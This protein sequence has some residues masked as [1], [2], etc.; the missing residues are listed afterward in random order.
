MAQINEH[1]ELLIIDNGSDDDTP[2]LGMQRAKENVQIKYCREDNLG[3]S[4]ARN[5]ALHDARGKYV[6]FLDDDATVA[7]GWLDEYV[8]FLGSPPSGKIVCVGGPVFPEFEKDRPNWLAANYGRLDY[9]GEMRELK[10]GPGP[11]GG[12]V[13]YDRFAAL[14]QGGF[15]PNLGRK[16]K[17]FGACEEYDLNLRLRQNGGE[18]WWLPG[19]AINHFM[20]SARLKLRHLLRVAFTEGRSSATLR[21][22][23]ISRAGPKTFFILLRI[24]GLPWQLIWS[25]FLAAS[26]LVGAKKTCVKAL[27]RASRALGFVRQCCS[28]F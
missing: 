3:L 8:R 20:P 25:F 16:G 13:A 23:Q 28:R 26:V 22:D 18:I 14:Q 5:R 19:A 17:T 2:Q 4:H 12:N 6:L 1:A 15:N 10:D 7:P 21:L 24:F 11:W 9:G 27:L